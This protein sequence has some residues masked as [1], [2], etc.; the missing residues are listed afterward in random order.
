MY[1]TQ[2][3]RLHLLLAIRRLECEIGGRTIWVE[4]R[5]EQLHSGIVI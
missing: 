3:K 5:I 4:D 2:F 1:K